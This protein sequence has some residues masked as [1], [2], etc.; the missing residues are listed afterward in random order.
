MNNKNY[1][2]AI[3]LFSFLL[4]LG[5]YPAQAQKIAEKSNLLWWATVSPNIGTEIALSNQWSLDA[6]FS[7]HPWRIWET[8]NL[9]HWLVSPELR[10]WYCRSYEGSFWGVHALAGQFNVRA[11]PLT[12]MPESYDYAGFLAGGGLSYG[13][14]LPLSARWSLEF[15]VGGGYVWIS[16]DKYECKE[17]RE[18]IATGYY[19]YFG[20]TRVGLSLIYFLQ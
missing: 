20:P 9:R 13:Y 17:C 18:K 14:H 10:W 1:R 4:L 6:T 5:A 2:R 12:G 15:T 11:L 19:N 3:L 16:Y 7:Y 8:T